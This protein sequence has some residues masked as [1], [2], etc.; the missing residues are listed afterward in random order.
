MIVEIGS[1]GCAW[2]RTRQRE[3]ASEESESARLVHRVSA[4]WELG[5]CLLVLYK[6]K[7]IS[8]AMR[9]AG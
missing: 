5:H 6:K 7:Y 9:C 3:G 1:T 2:M 8:V 4:N